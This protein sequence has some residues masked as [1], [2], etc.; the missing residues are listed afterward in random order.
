MKF[1]IAT[2]RRDLISTCDTDEQRE[3]ITLLTD[4]LIEFIGV[5]VE[6]LVIECYHILLGTFVE[7]FGRCDG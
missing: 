3:N 2:L 1:D 7:N 4:E 6:D 5:E